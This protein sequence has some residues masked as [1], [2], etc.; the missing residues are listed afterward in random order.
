MSSDAKTSFGSSRKLIMRLA[1]GCCFVFSI[2]ISLLF[3]ENMATSAPDM[4]NTNSNSTNNSK[5][6]RVAPCGLVARRATEKLFCKKTN[7]RM[8]LQ[9]KVF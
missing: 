3:K 2:L 7:D 5:T 9:C 1:A 6:N 4:V 8:T